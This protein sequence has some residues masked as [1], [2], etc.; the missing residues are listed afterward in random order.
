MNNDKKTASAPEPPEAPPS[1]VAVGDLVLE[2]RRK[3]AEEN[4]QLRTKLERLQSGAA[5]LRLA[6]IGW[7][8]APTK[9]PCGSACT[10]R[11]R[12]LIRRLDELTEEGD[13]G[14]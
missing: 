14:Q 8:D 6:A 5:Q 1:H 9:A 11:Y 12:W 4:A 3:L 2:E 10:R 13:Q 7:E